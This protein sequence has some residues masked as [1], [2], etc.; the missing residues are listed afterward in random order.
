MAIQINVRHDIRKL[1]EHL[2]WLQKEQIPYATAV[3]INAT[4]KQAQPAVQAEMRGGFG[5]PKPRAL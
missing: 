3:A 4:L 2:T 1:T 5:R